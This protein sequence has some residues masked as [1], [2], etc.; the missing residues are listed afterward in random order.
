MIANSANGS[1]R[2]GLTLLDQAIAYGNGTLSKDDVG[3]LLGTIDPEDFTDST[4]T[5]TFTVTVSD[6]YQAVATAKEFNV[7]VD[8]PGALAILK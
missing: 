5:Y 4:R 1:V 2:D 6:Q 7:T 8:I 3:N